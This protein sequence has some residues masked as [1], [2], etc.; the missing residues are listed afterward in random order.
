MYNDLFLESLAQCHAQMFS[1]WESQ[2]NEQ[3]IQE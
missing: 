1:Q 2:L 3:E